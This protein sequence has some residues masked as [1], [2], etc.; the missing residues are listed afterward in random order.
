[1]LELF[2]TWIQHPE[3]L[4][5]TGGYLGVALAVFA[6]SGLLIG[7]FLPGDSLLFAAGL[8][9]ASGYLAL[10][11]LLALVSL[12]AILGDSAGYWFGARVGTRLFRRPD[13][14]IFKQEYI[15]RTQAFYAR[16]GG[17]AIIY[18]RFVPIV[19][20]LTPVLAGVGRMPYR[21]FLAFNIVGGLLWGVGVSVLGYALGA[22]FPT[23]GEHLL[24]VSLAIIV[25][26]LMP[27]V[28][29]AIRAPEEVLTK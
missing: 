2:Y 23:V 4:V 24:P 29:H 12:A 25:L 28:Y 20:T 9:A 27:M 17:R 3:I 14:R 19:R 5:E 7:M 18:A 6:E 22:S 8:L 21:T 16:Y 10:L 15:T 1:M 26:S 11:P 13:S